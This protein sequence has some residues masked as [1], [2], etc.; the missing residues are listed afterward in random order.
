MKGLILIK[1]SKESYE[2][3][4]FELLKLGPDVL[5]KF[6]QIDHSKGN[7]YLVFGKVA[8]TIK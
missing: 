8:F 5:A 1:I 3:V 4:K 2:A 7:E 6:L